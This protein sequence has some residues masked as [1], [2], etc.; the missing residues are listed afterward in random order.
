MSKALIVKMDALDIQCVGQILAKSGF[1]QDAR[2][3]AQAIVKVLAGAELGF[4]PVASM[5]GI[6]IIKGKVT[7]SANLLAAAVKRSGRYNYRVAELSAERCKL[8]FL[9]NGTEI[10]VSE[11][12]MKD[13]KAAGLSGDNWRKYARNMLFARAMSNGV[14]WY[15]PDI[16]GGPVY[17]PDELGAAI[18]GETGEV[19][20]GEYKTGVEDVGVEISEH[21]VA[22]AMGIETG[23][24]TPFADLT[25]EQLQMIYSG[26][27][28]KTGNALNVTQEQR[29]AAEI[30]LQ[31]DAKP[32]VEWLKAKALEESQVGK[33]EKSVEVGA[34]DDIADVIDF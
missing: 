11:F 15:C 22:W 27:N 13:A 32:I 34:D 18:D 23:Q 28:A 14:R 25:P 3:E 24:G 7:L 26:V 8:V 19:I 1:F 6:H 16:S 29:D 9:E 33:I 4:G 30:L 2:Q 5:T 12:T 10:G 20:E 21:T 31:E 17:E